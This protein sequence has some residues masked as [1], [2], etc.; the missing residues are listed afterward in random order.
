[1][2]EKLGINEPR[3]ALYRF[4]LHPCTSSRDSCESTKTTIMQYVVS[5]NKPTSVTHSVV[6]NF[7]GPYDLNLILSKGT[8]IE[9][10][11]IG[12]DNIQ[13][14]YDVGLYGRIST[15]FL[16]RAKHEKQDSLWLSTERFKFC[17]LYYDA[18]KGEIKT[19]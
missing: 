12:D 14:Q 7:T 13:A 3:S 1:M 2:P 18:E 5:A 6:G 16:F 4:L 19:R 17:I 15:M 10:F 8:R 11:G 9:I